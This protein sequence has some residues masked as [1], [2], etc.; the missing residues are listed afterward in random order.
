MFKWDL[1]LKIGRRTMIPTVATGVFVGAAVR[2]KGAAVAG[3]VVGPCAGGVA[4]AGR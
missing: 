4:G 1:A 3:V 2:A